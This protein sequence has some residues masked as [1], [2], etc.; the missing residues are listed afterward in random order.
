MGVRQADAVRHMDAIYRTQRH[1]YDFTRK[2]YLFGRDQLLDG[3]PV[4][5]GARVCE[6]GCGTGRNL[7]RLARRRPDLDLYG[8][9]VSTVMLETAAASIARAGLAH[10]IRLAHAGGAAFDAPAAFGIDAFDVAYFSYVLS[11]IPD[12]A[13]AVDRAVGLVRPGGTLAVVDFG[14]QGRAGAW[15]RIPLLA[16]LR[17]FD[18]APRAEIEAGLRDRAAAWG[19]PVMERDIGRGYAYLLMLRKPF[20][21][22]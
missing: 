6:I 13:S 2:F 9:D 10:R 21:P 19:G 5:P 18:V 1:F 15:R 7:I 8:I 16:W 14:D 22:S 11:M 12:W 20:P 17:L 4:A 3:L